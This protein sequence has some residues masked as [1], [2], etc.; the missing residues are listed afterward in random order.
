MR[1]VQNKKKDLPN[2]ILLLLLHNSRSS[3]YGRFLMRKNFVFFSFL[4]T[5]LLTY[6][7]F[8]KTSET[9]ILVEPLKFNWYQKHLLKRI[10]IFFVEKTEKIE[11]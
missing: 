6:Y 5:F 4:L 3:N 2:Y 7:I 11:L 8:Q 1:T 9:A 10:S